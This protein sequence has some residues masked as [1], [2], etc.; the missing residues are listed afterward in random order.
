M[1]GL[2]PQLGGGSARDTDPSR[3]C[4]VCLAVAAASSWDSW[5]SP[6]ELALV[7]ACHTKEER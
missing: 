5:N 2:S 7:G 1:Q 3:E 6:S 4:S